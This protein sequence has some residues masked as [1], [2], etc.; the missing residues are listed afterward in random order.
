MGGHRMGKSR[1]TST[2]D[3]YLETHDVPG[4]YL[5]TAGAYPTGGVSNPTLT[6]VALTMRMADRILGRA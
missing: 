1:D 3:S 2:T 6:T 4:L 5:A